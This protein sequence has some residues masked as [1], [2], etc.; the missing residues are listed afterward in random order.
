MKK[1]IL[2]MLNLMLFACGGYAAADGE[3]GAER[4]IAGEKENQVWLHGLPGPRHK[5]RILH[6]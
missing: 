6:K 3:G 2:V 5:Y 4:L 1:R